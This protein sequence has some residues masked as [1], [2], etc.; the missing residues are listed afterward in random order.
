MPT[1]EA[2]C[3]IHIGAPK[4]GSTFLQR[5][6]CENRLVL[7]RAGLLYPEISLRG[8]GHHDIAFLLAGGYPDWATPQERSLDDLGK[9]LAK[10]VESHA[11]SILLSSEDFYLFPEPA[12]LVSFLESAGALAGRPARIVV[13]LRRQDEAHE[14]WYN[15][16]VKAQGETGA[17]EASLSRFYDLWDYQSRLAPWAAAF[18]EDALVVRRYVPP[19]EDSPSLIDDM[20]RV[21]AIED[22]A[23]AAPAISINSGENRDILEFQRILNQL[24][25]SVQEKRRFHKE[26][27]A[28]SERARGQGLFDE[29]PLLD[30]GARGT[31]MR[32]YERSNAAVAE[33]WFAG[34]P[35]FP[36]TPAKAS[37]EEA[38]PPA[39]ETGLTTAKMLY[40]LGW[41]LAYKA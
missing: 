24:P 32:R 6:F 31:L 7:G 16:R 10:A 20:M 13:Y 41:L 5:V 34:A 21:L 1:G 30:L 8:F 27:I 38:A 18:G 29:R 4:T 23:P 39:A 35:L 15:Q 33:R 3:Y 2:F 11:G 19:A 14:S 37:A 9:D 40:I 12:R 26:L 25:L 36:E 17:I 28:L 22:F